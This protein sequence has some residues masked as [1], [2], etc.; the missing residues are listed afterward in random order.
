VTIIKH[1]TLI[2]NLAPL[3]L[4][5]KLNLQVTFNPIIVKPPRRKYAENFSQGSTLKTNFAPPR[6]CGKSE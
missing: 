3:P 4:C 2:S 6:L 5:G 1:F